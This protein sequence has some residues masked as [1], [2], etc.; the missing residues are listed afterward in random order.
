MKQKIVLRTIF[1]ILL[2]SL[3]VG[4]FTF[5]HQPAAVS[6]QVSGGLIE[7]MLAA[8][9]SNF[10]S[11]SEQARAEMIEGLQHIVRK[12]AHAFVYTVMGVLSMS[13]M[14]TFDFR[15]IKSAAVLAFLISFMYAV[16][17]EIHQLFIDGRSGQIS[18]VVL[19]SFGAVFGIAVVGFFVWIARK[20]RQR[21]KIKEK[22]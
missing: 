11:L 10:D 15:K 20:R 4:I 19:D 2:I 6:S 3:M 21:R 8:F 22:V 12:S 5:S 9:M 16:S 13:F 18:D 1:L 14:L 17:D 7:R